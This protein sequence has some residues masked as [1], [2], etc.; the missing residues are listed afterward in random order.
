MGKEKD[1]GIYSSSFLFALQQ[2][3]GGYVPLSKA[4]PLL[5]VPL[6]MATGLSG[7]QEQS[8]FQTWKWSDPPLLDPSFFTIFHLFP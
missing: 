7:F 5:R 1:Q 6:P 3:Y 4:T 2:F 8:S